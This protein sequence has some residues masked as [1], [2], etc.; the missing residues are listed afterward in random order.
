MFGIGFQEILIIL[1]IVLILFGPKRLPDLAKSIGKG[2]AEF[3]KA[4]D[5][6]RQGIEEAIREEEAKPEGKTPEPPGAGEASQ[7][8]G[9]PPS[10]DPQAARAEEGEIPPSP[11]LSG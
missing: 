5:E 7:G 1:V 9:P 11:G 6:V 4:S 10:A 2:V 8:A 3:K